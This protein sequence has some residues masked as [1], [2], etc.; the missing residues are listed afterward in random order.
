MKRN[1]ILFLITLCV[2]NS[3]HI[4][5]QRYEK[6][7]IYAIPLNTSFA[8]EKTDAN[9]IRVN[10][11]FYFSSTNKNYIE[12]LSYIIF[13]NLNNDSICMNFNYIDVSSRIRV[14]IDFIKDEKIVSFALMSSNN[15][16]FVSDSYNNKE[17]KLLLEDKDLCKL[18]DI[19]P[20][21]ELLTYSL[22]KCD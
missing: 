20:I 17:C 3:L 4:Y 12:D 22:P 21:F 13:E 14:V 2:L 1:S 9:Y 8:I 11:D 18:I 10:R 6:V 19:L 5:C 7:N 16:L 15:I